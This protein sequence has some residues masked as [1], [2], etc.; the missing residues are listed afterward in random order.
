[1]R[2][3]LIDRITSWE[4]GRSGSASKNIALSEDFF[5]DHFPLQPIMPGTLI[6]EGM[7]QLA[8]LLLVD[9]ARRDTGRTH[10]VMLSIVDKVK[11][12]QPAR[13]GDTLEYRAEIVARNEVGGRVS[14]R[15]TR[16][17]EVVAEGTLTLS[18]REQEGPAPATGWEEM[19][20]RWL[21]NREAIVHE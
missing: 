20:T 13:P 18:L 15:A 7:A 11:L 16:G 1:M 5:E 4:P 6:L 17:E 8:G 2:F 9:A 3:L 21:E 14:V 12:R 10:Q 19:L